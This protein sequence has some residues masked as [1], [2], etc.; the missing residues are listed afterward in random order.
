MTLS[1]WGQP[2]DALAE[3]FPDSTPVGY[4]HFPSMQQALEEIAE[5]SKAHDIV[6]GWSLGGRLA[7]QA[8]LAGR[9]KPK[10]LVLIAS[11]FQFSK[12]TELPLGI[13]RDQYEKFRG[14]YQR[15]ALRTLD[16]G[17]ELIV[18]GDK[19]AAR[20]RSRFSDD[21]KQAMLA[22][23]WLR[24]LDELNGLTLHGV[25]L[26]NMPQTLLLHGVNDVVVTPDQSQHY[27]SLLPQAKL[28]MLDDCG[29]AP[30][31]HDPQLVRNTVEEF[32]RV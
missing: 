24:W 16:K 31:W 13:P 10:K 20:I 26:E 1:G 25:S 30:H 15:N 7:V 2:H 29:H 9:M 21:A 4:A 3:A 17:W 32:I 23:D 27:T 5:T 12:S 14:N 11:A 8:I 22:H 6:V 19:H 28:V 18:K